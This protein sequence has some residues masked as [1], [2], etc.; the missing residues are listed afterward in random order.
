MILWPALVG[1]GLA[2][3]TGAALS[4]AGLFH[5]PGLVGLI[6]IAVA[7]FWPLFAV[8]AQ[9]DGQVMFHIAIFAAFAAAAL[10]SHRIGM[11]GLALVLIAHGVLD[12]V[13]YT[14]VHPGPVWWPAFC[15][16]YD[17]VLGGMILLFLLNSPRSG[18]TT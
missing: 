11:A 8:A 15:A 10:A 18:H 17:V 12:S 5:R 13:L 9:N 14:T 7:G 3:A 16:G 4:R 2:A 1:G 6:I